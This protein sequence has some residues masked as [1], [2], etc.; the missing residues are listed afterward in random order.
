MRNG[1]RIVASGLFFVTFSFVLHGA[2]DLSKFYPNIPP[3]KVYDALVRWAERSNATITDRDE[4]TRTI[5]YNVYVRGNPN[6]PDMSVRAWVEPD[7]GGSGSKLTVRLVSTSDWLGASSPPTDAIDGVNT[8][9]GL[10]PEWASNP[11]TNGVFSQKFDVPPDTLFS[12][13]IARTEKTGNFTTRY[14]LKTAD[15]KA[16]TLS[17]EIRWAKSAMRSGLDDTK[18][19]VDAKVEPSGD[20]SNLI[21]HVLQP[22]RGFKPKVGAEGVFDE[23]KKHLKESR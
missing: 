4:K 13:L 10:P 20:G 2:G 19:I 14:V 17:F 5:A 9:F 12:A 7:E 1:L 21:L 11:A 6:L 15:E 22:P 3:D 8:A 23:M 18:W 16:H